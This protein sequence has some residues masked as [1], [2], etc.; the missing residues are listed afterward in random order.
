MSDNETNHYIIV[1]GYIHKIPVKKDI[2]SDG[3]R[4]REKEITNQEKNEYHE[5]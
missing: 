3:S 2:P 5:V 4:I 1:K